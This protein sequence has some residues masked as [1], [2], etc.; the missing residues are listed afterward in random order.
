MERKCLISE[1]F[2]SLQGEG[3]T[4]GVPS[5][6]VRFWG[7]NLRCTFGGKNCD[8][9]YAVTTGIRGAKHLTVK[10]VADKI[11]ASNPVCKHIVFT[12][13]EPLLYQE[14]ITDLIEILDEGYTYEVETNGTQPV[15]RFLQLVVKLFNVSVKLKSSKQENEEFDRR[16]INRMALKTF[17]EHKT[18]FKFVVTNKKDM[19]EIN[20][21]VKYYKFETYLMPEGITREAIDKKIKLVSN[22]CLEHNYSFS[23]RLHI[24]LWGG[25]RGK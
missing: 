14:F 8:T 11:I 23:S 4:V 5:I 6:F 15:S 13:G 25:K 1:I 2:Y 16:R 18:I 17:P 9:P 10:Q 7:C 24:T 19:E 21:L 12:G 22:L 3:K 20:N